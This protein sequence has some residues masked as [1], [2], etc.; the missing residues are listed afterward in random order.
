MRTYPRGNSYGLQIQ[1]Q[2]DV[3]VNNARYANSMHSTSDGEYRAMVI[4]QTGFIGNIRGF[5]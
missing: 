1:D 2:G 5:E 3:M 4:D